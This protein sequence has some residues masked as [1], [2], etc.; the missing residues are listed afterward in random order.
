[1]IPEPGLN[2]IYARSLNHCIGHNGHL[3]W[4]LPAEYQH[5][6]SVTRGYPLIMGRVSYQDHDGLL[7]NCPNIIVSS[8]PNLDV[9]PE[10]I[11]STNLKQAIEI[12]SALSPSYFVIGGAGLITQALPETSCVFESIVD[13]E[14]TGDTFLSDMDFDD[15]HTETLLTHDVDDNHAFGFTCY[16]HIAN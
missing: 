3:P 14:I 11:L 2:I 6:E 12:A 5:F 7:P 8:N 16:K 10:A 4:H 13:A 15:W 1:M 9:E